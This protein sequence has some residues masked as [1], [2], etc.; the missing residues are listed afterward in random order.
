[1]ET[2]HNPSPGENATRVNSRDAEKAFREKG[3]ETGVTTSPAPATADNTTIGDNA[4]DIARQKS[5]E[6]DVER[7]ENVDETQFVTGKKL[8]LAHTGFLLYVR[9]SA[10]GWKSVDERL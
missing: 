10:R 5:L 8:L 1:M 6:A 7:Q 2:P 9:F 4:D 3:N